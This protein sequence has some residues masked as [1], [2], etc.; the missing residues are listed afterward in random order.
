MA[1]ECS[2]PALPYGL[3]DAAR[4]MCCF[5]LVAITSL[6]SIIIQWIYELRVSQILNA[7]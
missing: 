3:F 1:T 7:L 6:K 2:G 5:V 4:T